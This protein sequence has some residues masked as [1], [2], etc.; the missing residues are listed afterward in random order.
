MT[1]SASSN[2]NK[3]LCGV[4]GDPIAHSLSPKIHAA[5]GKQF[6]L[7]LAYHKYQVSSDNFSHF[8][9]DFFAQGGR[10]LNVTLPHKAAACKIAKN[11]SEDAKLCQ[12]VNTLWR[13][14]LGM[15]C[16]DSTDGAG[17][18]LDLER[19]QFS[20]HKKNILVVGAGGAAKS[21]IYS[22]LIQDA[23]LSV[24][25]RTLEKIIQLQNIFSKVGKI[26]AFE[27]EQPIFDGI[28]CALSEFNQPLYE[29]VI[30]SLKKDAFVYDLNYA[31]R[32]QQTLNY[33]KQQGFSR[34]S[35][36]YGMLCGQAAKSFE[37]WHGVLPEV[38]CRA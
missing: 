4:V 9:M 34:I 21:I 28:I 13:D 8:V 22:L 30:S 11:V 36:G 31:G 25:N 5:F 24:Q 38:E 35:D 29:K 12:S 15:I 17:F 32:A 14:R 10:G 27:T 3:I 1:A 18:L 20:I 16:G 7:D 6:N 23:N 19:L 26:S 37:I 2:S 33:F